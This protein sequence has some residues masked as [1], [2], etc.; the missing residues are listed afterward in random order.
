MFHDEVLNGPAC[1]VTAPRTV[2]PDADFNRLNR[3]GM[4]AVVPRR[5]LSITQMSEKLL[6]DSLPHVSCNDLMESQSIFEFFCGDV[7]ARFSR[8]QAEPA[9]TDERRPHGKDDPV[10][11]PAFPNH[12][13]HL[14][15]NVSLSAP[16]SDT[17]TGR[18]MKPFFVL[19]IGLFALANCATTTVHTGMPMDGRTSASCQTRDAVDD[20]SPEN[21]GFFAAAEDEGKKRDAAAA[22]GQKKD[23]AEK[24]ADKTPAK[25]EAKDRA[26]VNIENKNPQSSEKDESF[27]VTVNNDNGKE[28]DPAKRDMNVVV[29]NSA[30]KKLHVEEGGVVTPAVGEGF[31]QT[32]TAS[33]YGRDFDG[34]KTA[35]GQSFDSRAM[36]AA[37][38]TL[39]LGTQIEVKNLENGRE[40][41]V[42]VNDRG[43]YIKG[44]I[45]DLSE[46]AAEVLGY[47]ERGLTTVQL[48]VIAPGQVKETGRGATE[49]LYS[50]TGKGD[51]ALNSDKRKMSDEVSPKE[52]ARDE[53]KSKS[54]NRNE[55]A[56]REERRPER[57]PSG[58]TN[59][60]TPEESAGVKREGDG[61]GFAVQVGIFS[62]LDRAREMK[63]SMSS[64]GPV[65]IVKR[66]EKYV[67][68]V[69]T[70][71]KRKDADTLKS[72][73]SNEGYAAFV[74]KG[75]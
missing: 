47:K 58:K 54:E 26:V 49:G 45:L 33:W 63:A 31:E 36:T 35:S 1:P 61:D 75:I 18:A 66:G 25:S 27:F 65:H 41:V 55:T 13:S 59:R 32:G 42:L 19:I 67:V 48:R 30:D 50:D 69:G 5:G 9:K 62:E 7:M 12:S 40:T 34:K 60:L 16:W 44:R 70:F 53:S 72:R 28:Q 68:K 39:P 10:L 73:L 6:E 14:L 15:K 64:Y 21:A 2:L 11:F 46:K 74:S 23:E 22:D 29:N 4:S 3:N 20:E 8:M 37:H 52:E 57:S 38:R 51:A 71:K 43:P 24:P 56:D 17:R